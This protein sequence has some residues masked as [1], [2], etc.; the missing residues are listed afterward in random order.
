VH[1]Q[2]SWAVSGQTRK[3]QQLRGRGATVAPVTVVMSTSQDEV[4][5]GHSGPILP[6]S[7]S[8]SALLR[9]ALQTRSSFA[10]EVTEHA[11]PYRSL[12][13]ATLRPSASS[14]FVSVR[15]EPASSQPTWRMRA[16]I[17]FTIFF[18]L[19]LPACAA[20][21][22]RLQAQGHTRNVIPSSTAA[23]PLSASTSLAASATASGA[24]SSITSGVASA[25]ASASP[26]LFPYGKEPIRGVNLWVNL[27]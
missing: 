6:G 10:H 4:T 23:N 12:V 16:A 21:Q 8:G 1:C 20:Q 14:S 13:H 11:T 9:S 24:A 2:C 27:T 26:T 15:S 22:C 7:L 3:L 18:A 5:Q 19:G 17:C 25:S